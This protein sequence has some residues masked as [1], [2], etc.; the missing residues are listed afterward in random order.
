MLAFFGAALGS[1]AHDASVF[2]LCIGAAHGNNPL[3]FALLPAKAIMLLMLPIVCFDLL[4]S[5]PATATHQHPQHTLMLM[6]LPIVCFDQF[7]SVLGAAMMLMMLPVVCFASLPAA[8]MMLMMLPVVCSF[9]AAHDNDVHYASEI[10][11]SCGGNDAHDA[12]DC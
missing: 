6:M 1:Y 10:L 8:S 12:S 11:L 7:A 4:R 9:A 3:R 5:V 2:L